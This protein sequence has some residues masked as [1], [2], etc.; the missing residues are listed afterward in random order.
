MCDSI[1]AMFTGAPVTAEF[2]EKIGAGAYAKDV[3]EAYLLQKKLL[4]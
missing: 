3:G 2:A 4:G 1:K